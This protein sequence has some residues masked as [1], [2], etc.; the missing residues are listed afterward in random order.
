MEPSHLSPG[1]EPDLGE[2][3]KGMQKEAEQRTFAFLFSVFLTGRA[4]GANLRRRKELRQS[5]KRHNNKQ[6]TNKRNS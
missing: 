1:Y 6:T 3:K 2:K 5:G 4:S